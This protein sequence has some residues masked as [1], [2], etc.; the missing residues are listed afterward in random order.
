MKGLK[1]IN[2]GFVHKT[3]KQ[4]QLPAPMVTC[5]THATHLLP[6]IGAN[7]F[8]TPIHSY[9]YFHVSNGF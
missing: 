7:S 5:I 8:Y 3:I 6:I 9:S 2:V 1:G 4:F